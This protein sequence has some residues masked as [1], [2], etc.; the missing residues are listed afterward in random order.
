MMAQPQ[1]KH[2]TTICSNCNDAS[3]SQHVYK[4]PASGGLVDSTPTTCLNC[5]F[6]STWGVVKPQ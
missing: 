4:Q 3:K 6:V 1:N 2:G 5:G